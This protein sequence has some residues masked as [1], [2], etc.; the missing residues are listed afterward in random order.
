MGL[1]RVHGQPFLFALA[2]DARTI[3]ASWN[4]DWRSVFETAM[5]ADR[6]VHLRVIGGD[7]VIERTV[8]VEP[9]TAMHYV[10]I[11]VLHKS[12]CVEFGYFQSFDTWHSVATGDEIEIP[13]LGRVGVAEVDL[14]TIPF[15]LS[16][17]QL[18]H[19][20]GAATNTPVARV[21]SE[22]ENRVL[23][24]H[25]PNKTTRSDMQI[26]RHLNLT[27]RE[28]ATA[29]RD[30]KARAARPSNASTHR[31]QSSARIPSEPRLVSTSAGF[32]YFSKLPGDSIIK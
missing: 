6:Q 21:V 2:R 7:G 25:S 13:P 26:L 20:L 5:P 12:Y 27:L 24:T 16:F 18:A 31:N 8:A 19:R 15:H 29:E 4:I 22:F 17:Q 3:F 9:M 30:S 28:I 14:G 1:T 23:G 10:T 32:S 11:S